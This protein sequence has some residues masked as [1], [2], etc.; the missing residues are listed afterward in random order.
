MGAAENKAAVAA[1][2][3]AFGQ[4]DVASVIAMNAPDATWVNYSTDASPLQGEFKGLDAIGAFFG[5]VGDSIEISEFDIAPIAAEG[6]IVVSHGHQT[7]T[8]K[9]TGKTVS[10]PV[11]HIFT[12]GPDGKVTRFEEWEHGTESAWA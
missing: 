1:A 2:Y 6:D 7:Y 10:G 8:V 11:L 3:E 5:V 4:G 12:F 9:K